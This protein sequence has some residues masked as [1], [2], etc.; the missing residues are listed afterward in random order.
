[1]M[2]E[3][4]V[5]KVLS[6]HPEIDRV[7]DNEQD[8][9]AS[10]YKD[11]EVNRGYVIKYPAGSVTFWVW[12]C[13]KDTA[14]ALV[15]R[16]C[17]VFEAA[18]Y[19]E[20]PPAQPARESEVLALFASLPPEMQDKVRRKIAGHVCPYCEQKCESRNGLARHVKEKHPT[21]GKE[22]IAGA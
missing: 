18:N 22:N 16:R 3:Q 12:A 11:Q 9:L 15:A 8:F 21:Q 20:P 5:P 1:M 2:D 19:Q 13:N 10:P 4:Q 17:K 7:F 6:K 14:L